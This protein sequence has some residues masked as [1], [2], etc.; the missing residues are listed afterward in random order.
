MGCK[1]SKV[2]IPPPVDD[3]KEKARQE[4]RPRRVEEEKRKLEDEKL[5]IEEKEI[6]I[7]LPQDIPVQQVPTELHLVVDNISTKCRCDLLND[8]TTPKA[9]M[10]FVP[11]IAV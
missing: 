5:H 10:T 9:K 8:S 4:E 6:I 11:M 1:T 3:A 2:V 7:E